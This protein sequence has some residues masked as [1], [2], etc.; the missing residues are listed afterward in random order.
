MGTLS[1]VAILSPT[2]TFLKW[3]GV[4]G[5]GSVLL[6]IAGKTRE[7]ILLSKLVLTREQDLLLTFFMAVQKRQ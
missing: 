5:V 6:T 4:L 7:L 1:T 3:G 2:K